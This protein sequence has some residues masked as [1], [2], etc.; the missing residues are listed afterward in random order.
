MCVVAKAAHAQQSYSPCPQISVDSKDNFSL[1][2]NEVTLICG[3]PT[4]LAYKNIPLYQ[5]QLY[6]SGFLQARGY[7]N[8]ESEIRDNQLYVQTKRKTLIRS[9]SIDVRGAQPVDD[10]V[11]IQEHLSAHFLGNILTPQELNTIEADV[12]RLLKERGYAC[13]DVKSAALATDGS[14]KVQINK[15]DLVYFGKIQT[16]NLKGI[17]IR[18]FERFYPFKKGHQYD[19]KKLELTEKRFLR[20]GIVEGSYFQEMCQMNSVDLKHRLLE[21]PPRLVRLGLGLSTEVGPMARA[22]WSHQRKGTMASYR[23]VNLQA[24]FKDQQARALMDEYLWEDSP[25]RSLFASIEWRRESQEDYEEMLLTLKPHLKWSLDTKN[26]NWQWILGPSFSVGRFSS[27]NKEAA[28][29][30]N[31]S[32]TSLEGLLQTMSHTFEY[33]DFHQQ[34]GHRL[35]LSVDLRHPDLGFKEP[36]AMGQFSALKIRPFTRLGKGFLIGALSANVSTTWVEKN[37]ELE[38]LPP[39]VKHFGGGSDD[40]RGFRLNTLPKNDGLGALTKFG[41]K[42]EMRKTHT[43]IS[44]LETVAF[45][46]LVKFG[47]R[48]FELDKTLWYSPGV[49]LRW[50]SPIGLIQGYVAQGYAVQPKKNDGLLF[51]IGLG[52]QF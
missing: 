18:A 2:A 25:R 8:A 36:L 51:F 4:D 43:F 24:S 37:V 6:L 13:A 38:T 15:A 32:S 19:I 23:E 48:P 12:K 49:G 41:L 17:N 7:L 30:E 29:Q 28:D 46:D 21:G 47:Q 10:Q 40:I 33:Y 22:R 14:V 34:N 31:Y 44:S 5:A 9:I 35:S 27:E 45:L 1:S 52:G 11:S 3:D 39:S 50:L 16:E 26:H 20:S 42:M